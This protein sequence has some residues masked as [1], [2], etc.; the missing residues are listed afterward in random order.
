MRS[1]RKEGDGVPAAVGERINQGVRTAAMAMSILLRQAGLKGD[2]AS[3]QK[4]VVSQACSLPLSS[5]GSLISLFL[6]FVST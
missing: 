3:A 5:F 1:G 6:C 4:E 2:V